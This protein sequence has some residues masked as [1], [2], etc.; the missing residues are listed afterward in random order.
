MVIN[1]YQQPHLLKLEVL[2]LLVVLVLCGVSLNLVYPE[3]VG[4]ARSARLSHS[5]SRCRSRLRQQSSCSALN[6]GSECVCPTTGYSLLDEGLWRPQVTT[7]KRSLGTRA[8]CT[9]LGLPVTCTA[10][11]FARACQSH[12]LNWQ[13]KTPI[14]VQ[15]SAITVLVLPIPCIFDH[16]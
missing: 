13:M 4:Q 5:H 15:G 9:R 8:Y 1:D 3:T 6:R 7:R 11:R 12:Q 2:R 16:A 10:L 14:I